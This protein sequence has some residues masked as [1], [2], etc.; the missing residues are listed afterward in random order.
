[1]GGSSLHSLVRATPNTIPRRH[2]G[3]STHYQCSNLDLDLL[4]RDSKGATQALLREWVYR[5]V[6]IALER[7]GGRAKNVEL[8]NEDF[9]RATAEMR[10]FSEGE[11]GRVIGF[12]SSD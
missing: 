6:Q 8:S 7:C 12:H 1:M 5:S 9:K 10:S 4:V 2:H 3:F 11:T